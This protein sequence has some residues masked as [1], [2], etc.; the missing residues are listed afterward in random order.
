MQKSDRSYK[1]GDLLVTF[2]TT[3]LERDNQQA[4][5]NLQS[6]YNTSQAARDKNAQAIDAANA[7]N[8]ELANQANALADQVNALKAQMDAAKATY[9]ANAA[10][11]ASA[12][13]QTRIGRTPR[14]DF[15][16]RTHRSRITRIRSRLFPSYMRAAE[17]LTVK[18]SPPRKISGPTHRKS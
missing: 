7:A 18:Q 16:S 6:A 2:D 5:L 3:N 12:E 1:A 9:D 13:T 10:A 15:R 4:Q 8:A 17:R 14:G 11:N